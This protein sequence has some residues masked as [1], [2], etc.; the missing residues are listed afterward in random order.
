MA[1]KKPAVT[2]NPKDIC[3]V[4]MPF[5]GWLDDYYKAIY[6]PAIEAV[7]LDPHRADDLFR[8]STIVND[9]WTYTRR[10][11]LLVADLT[12]KNPNVFYE[13]GI[14]HALAKPVVMIAESMEDI[15]FDLRALR[16]IIYDKNA[17][18]WGALLRSKIESAITEVLQAPVAA[19]LPAFLEVKASSEK[20]E[21]TVRERDLIAI[22]QELDLVKRELR[23]REITRHPELERRI[24]DPSEAEA[25]IKL[26]MNAGLSES[27]IVREL[28][29][30]GPPE[31][32]IQRK[33]RELRREKPIAP[34]PPPTAGKTRV[35]ALKT[36]RAKGTKA[37][38]GTESPAAAN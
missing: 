6:K 31:I 15:P 36:K 20:P 22:R 32:W 14:A 37:R 12:G 13:L 30:L 24:L 19:V 16:I 3:F 33:I 21:V 25:R 38:G 10:A 23:T 26:M 1:R 11:K 5:G 28:E 17:P 8:P 9:I 18:E 34:A 35:K 29:P 4:I 7:G 2:R 27:M